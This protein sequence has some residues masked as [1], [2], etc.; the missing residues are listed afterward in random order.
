MTPMPLSTKILFAIAA[1][2][3]LCLGGFIIYQ[4]YA[5]ASQLSE[6]QNSF[7]AQK[8]LLDNITRAQSLYAS[9]A[10]IDAYA[11]QH[12]IDLDVIKQDLGKLG[13]QVQAINGVTVVSQGQSKTSVSSTSTTPGVN[14]PPPTPGTDP[15]GYLTNTQHLELN[16]Q[17]A[18]VSVPFGNVGF[19]A[20]RDK[21]WDI[22]IAPRNYS[23]T[24]VLG[25]DENGKHY[26]YNKFAIQTGGKTYDVKIKDNTFLEEF[27]TAKFSW[28]NPRLFMFANGGVGISSL[29]VKGEFTPGVSVG[30]MSYGKTRTNPSLS[31]L[32]VGAGYGVANNT[33][34][35]SLSPIQYNIG[36][37]LPLTNNTYVGPTAQINTHGNITL[38]AG[39]SVGF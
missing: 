12:N 39:L 3:I 35:V 27:P 2:V 26:M 20:W 9:K 14:I 28:F 30:I 11:K 33:L 22:N 4:H 8:Q 6:M 7:V 29:P 17:F 34:E 13:A 36:Q 10:D 38:G 16:E 19:S 31:I 32:Q 25:Q 23:L 5:T 1:C 18:D 21:P 24:S 15:Y 37:N